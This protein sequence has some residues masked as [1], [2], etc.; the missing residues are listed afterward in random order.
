MKSDGDYVR[1]VDQFCLNK[2]N[3]VT[4]LYVV[5][6]VLTDRELPHRSYEVVYEL[7]QIRDPQLVDK[8]LPEGFYKYF[9]MQLSGE[10]D[11]YNVTA[12]FSNDA[13]RSAY[14]VVAVSGPVP[15]SRSDFVTER[16]IAYAIAYSNVEKL[17]DKFPEL[18]DSVKVVT[19]R[20]GGIRIVVRYVK[21]IESHGELK[22]FCDTQQ[23]DELELTIMSRTPLI[24][25]ADN[26]VMT[27]VDEENVDVRDADKFSFDKAIRKIVNRHGARV[28]RSVKSIRYLIRI[29]DID[30]GETSAYEVAYNISVD[31]KSETNLAT[32]LCEI[33]DKLQGKMFKWSYSIKRGR[34]RLHI[35]VV[36]ATQLRQ[37]IAIV[38]TT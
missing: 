11:V 31:V 9:T 23:R 5:D 30:I 2:I 21:Q 27:Y 6:A 1:Y 32:V 3:C 28:S 19:L 29:G 25:I 13:Y 36:E 4:K 14:L 18:R 10:I 37:D 17:V 8:I 20:R 26:I 34:R 35:R 33:I 38:T 22:T 7:R 12:K 24:E 16:K 15:Y